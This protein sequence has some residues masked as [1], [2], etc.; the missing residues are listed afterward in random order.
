MK[1]RFKIG[2]YIRNRDSISVIGVIKDINID[3]YTNEELPGIIEQD[4]Y[5]FVD[6]GENKFDWEIEEQLELVQSSEQISSREAVN[7]FIEE[8][9]SKIDNVFEHL[10]FLALLSDGREHKVS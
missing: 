4:S 10:Q 3:Q 7:K 5:Y 6:Y 1:P 2:D 9:K 8:L